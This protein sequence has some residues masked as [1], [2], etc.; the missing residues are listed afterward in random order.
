VECSGEFVCQ[1][2]IESLGLFFFLWMLLTKSAYAQSWRAI[3]CLERYQILCFV[4]TY[5]R[6]TCLFRGILEGGFRIFW[7]RRIQMISVRITSM[8]YF[9]SSTLSRLFSFHY[10]HYVMIQKQ[11]IHL[12]NYSL[13]MIATVFVWVFHSLACIQFS[14][15]WVSRELSLWF[16]AYVGPYCV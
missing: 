4:Y 9:E 12:S 10:C 3:K 6:W 5:F 15:L 11:F 2:F 16:F 1:I 7:K 13:S 8:C 14:V